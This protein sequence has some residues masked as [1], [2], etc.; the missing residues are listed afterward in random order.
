[1]IKVID[2]S[3][4]QSPTQIDYEKLASEVDGVILR[5]AY[6]T[7]LD[8]AFMTH[9]QNLSR[10]GVPL[11]F[12]HFI[13]QYDSV[14]AQ[15]NT[16]SAGLDRLVTQAS[17]SDVFPIEGWADVENESGAPALTKATVQ[18]YVNLALSQLGMK[19]NI[20][21]SR[22]YWDQ[23]INDDIF[24]DR[25]LW[26]AHYGA[27]SPYMPATGGWDKWWLWQYTSNGR[28]EAYSGSIDM[29]H[30]WGTDEEFNDWVGDDVIIPSPEPDEPLY[31][32]EIVNCTALNV[33]SGPG[34]SYDIVGALYNGDKVEVY[35][36]TAGWLNIEAGWISSAYTAIYQEPEPVEPTDAEKLKRLW[37]AHPELH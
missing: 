26:V 35:G 12:Y 7:H 9:F 34:V 13:T 33:R 21:T 15:I 17:F 16:L 24:S 6:G 18:N 20:Y 29:N 28:F 25:K 36:E 4:W 14:Q 10:L 32:A 30:F 23:I 37:D 2:I 11:G 8:T 5:L 1:M 19:L 22:Y 31:I 27:T 3:Y